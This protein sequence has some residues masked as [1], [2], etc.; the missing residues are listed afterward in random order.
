MGKA[1]LRC[2]KPSEKPVKVFKS[3][4]GE[5][6]CAGAARHK[7]DQLFLVNR[8]TAARKKH[9][10]PIEKMLLGKCA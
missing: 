9:D 8:N 2:D 1:T 6:G 3:R 5:G 4:G 10:V 7:Q